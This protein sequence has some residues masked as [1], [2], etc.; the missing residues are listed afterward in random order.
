MYVLVAV[1]CTELQK[2]VSRYPK[3][4][5]SKDDKDKIKKEGNLKGDHSQAHMVK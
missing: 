5:T 4:K 3:E 2:A 1:F